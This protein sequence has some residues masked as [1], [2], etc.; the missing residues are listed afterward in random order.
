MEPQNVALCAAVFLTLRKRRVH[1]IIER[2]RCIRARRR[3]DFRRTQSRQ[4]MMFAVLLSMAALKIQ[5]PVR[6]IWMKPRSNSWWEDVLHLHQMIGLKTLE[7]QRPHSCMSCGHQW[8]RMTPREKLYQWNSSYSVNTCGFSYDWSLVWR[9]QIDRVCD[10]KSK[11]VMLWFRQ[12]YQRKFDS[13]VV[14]V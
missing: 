3:R 1:D 2:R 12:C 10:N 14:M 9:I 11:F 13:P 7:C 4:R 5:S 6:S 8:K